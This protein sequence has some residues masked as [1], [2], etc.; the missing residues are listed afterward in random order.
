M[1]QFLLTI[2]RE[3]EKGEVPH[4]LIF[5]PLS[6]FCT[7]ALAT[8][9]LMRFDLLFV[10]VLGL[11]VSARWHLRGCVYVLV[12]LVLTSLIHHLALPIHHLW[13]LGLE[14][15]VGF[16]FFITAVSFEESATTIASLDSGLEVKE[17]AIRNLE[18]D[19]SKEKEENA[20]KQ[21]ASSEKFAALQK[22]LE[23]LQTEQSSL[24]ILNDVLRKTT[25]RHLEEKVAAE[26]MLQGA[27]SQIALFQQEL[28]EKSRELERISNENGLAQ[29]NR[30][31]FEEA[32]GARV[33]RE[34]TNQINAMLVRLHAKEALKAK[35]AEA[36]LEGV[37]T[38]RNFLRERLQAAEFELQQSQ[39]ISSLQHTE[40]L[41]RQ[42]KKQFEEKN[43]ILHQTRAELFQVN[44][45]LEALKIEA[46]QK[47]PLFPQAVQ[48][49]MEEVEKE[50]DALQKENQELLDLVSTLGPK[51]TKKKT[52]MN[53]SSSDF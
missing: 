34:Q 39:P 5:G 19:L 17:A 53:S 20:A 14:I 47:E 7:F 4:W 44:T 42:L 36:Q 48:K 6:L 43:E 1:R 29:Q 8:L 51:A 46:E 31:L 11:Y 2:F 13:Q 40:S 10:G 52:S 18:E 38:E 22:E 30:E 3:R 33:E 28:S 45:A 24:L 32:N 9:P 35:E 12:L 49:E 50:L 23:E 25:A 27:N 21:I 15:S 41:Y 37:A 26:K 16:A